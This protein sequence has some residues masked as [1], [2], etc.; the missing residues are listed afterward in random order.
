LATE[1]L[2]ILKNL[3][4][5]YQYNLS[6]VEMGKIDK[7]QFLFLVIAWFVISYIIMWLFGGACTDI[8]SGGT[9][10]ASN[11][12]S[13]LRSVPIIG[14][15]LPY[16]A[17]VSLLYWFAPVAGFVLAF[18]GI[19]WYNKYF[20]TKEAAGILFLVLIVVAL[21][22]GYYINLSWYYGEAA[23]L[24]SKNGVTVGL[25]FC[26]DNDPNV[27]NE[28]VNKLNNELQQQSTR[29]NSTSLTQLF[30]VQYWP[31]LRESIFLTF[32]LGAIAAWIPLFAKQFIEKEESEE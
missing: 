26:F 17:W 27:C 21:F 9:C 22:S 1:Q 2:L 4:L 6:G 16:N 11:G 10:M 12:I 18:F 28:T 19:Q 23:T 25:H 30:N 13:F 31:E 15:I 5:F 14:L 29:N 3:L 24:N 32:I 20:E 7:K 8:L